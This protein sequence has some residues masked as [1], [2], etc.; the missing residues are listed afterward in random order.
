MSTTSSLTPTERVRRL[1]AAVDTLNPQAP[2]EHIADDVVFRFGNNDLIIGKPAFEESGVQFF[3]S[4]ASIHHELLSIWAPEPDVVITEMNVT[5]GR[6]DD[7]TLTLPCCNVFRFKD[8]L[9]AT[10]TIYMDIGPVF[11]E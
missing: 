9:I 10:Y 6:Q 7:S 4:L 8:G 2:L 3:G 5:Y 11:A 1:F